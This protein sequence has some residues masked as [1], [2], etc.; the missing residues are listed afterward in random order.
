MST[1]FRAENVFYWIGNRME[2]GMYHHDVCLS[3]SNAMAILIRVNCNA[4]IGYRGEIIHLKPK[5]VGVRIKRNFNFF[6]S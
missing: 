1:R 4:T 6:K 2:I 5:L 3:K